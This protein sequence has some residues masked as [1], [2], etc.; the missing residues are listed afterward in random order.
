LGNVLGGTIWHS[1]F[2]GPLAYRTLGRKPFSQLQEVIFPRL[3]AFQTGTALALASLYGRSAIN[4]VQWSRFYTSSDRNVWCLAVMAASGVANWFVVGPWTTKVMK[5]RH[6]RERLEDKEY[7]DE[8]VS[9]EMKQLTRRFAVLHSVASLL[10][11]AFI[12]A[13][14]THAAYLAAFPPA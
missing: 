9:P 14:A 7:N 10:N 2:G 8:N 13:A 12:S 6:R 3:F 1:F 11:L 5:R 4:K